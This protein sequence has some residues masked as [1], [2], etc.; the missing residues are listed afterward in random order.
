MDEFVHFLLSNDT[1]IEEFMET[2]NSDLIEL[3]ETG[4]VEIALFGKKFVLS[5]NIE[6]L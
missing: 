1:S 6:E 4:S 3:V 2:H 5:V